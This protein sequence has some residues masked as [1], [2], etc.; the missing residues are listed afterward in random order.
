MLRRL[1]ASLLLAVPLPLAAQD[2]LVLQTDFGLS[3][4]S[5]AEMKGVAFRVSRSIPMFDLTHLIPPF[6][7]LEAA[8]RLRQT[9]PVW[10]AGTVFVSVVDP[11]VGTAR[12]AVVA[13]TRRG[14][15]IVTPDNGTL[16]LVADA[17]GVHRPPADRCEAQ[18]ASRLG[19]LAHLP[20][21]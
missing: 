15:L 7:I 13:R 18:P 6:D 3:E 20:W 19:T 4:G 5:V 9:V 12:R 10:P 8:V 2:A 21:P 1:I 14:H 16:T 17:L 11:G